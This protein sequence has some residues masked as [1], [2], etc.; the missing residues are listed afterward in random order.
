MT[1]KAWEQ[2][3]AKY[4]IAEQIAQKGL[5][6]ISAGQIKEF[7][8]PRLM[9]KFDHAINRPSIF[10]D[11]DLA[12]L[13]TSRGTYAISQFQ[14]YRLLAKPFTRGADKRVHCAQLRVFLRDSQ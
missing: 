14:A 3:F 6:S 5:Y 4:G 7:R 13:P 1:E 9:A 8:E 12:I 2:L 11:S 10:Q